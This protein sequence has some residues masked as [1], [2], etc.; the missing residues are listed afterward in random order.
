M[1]SENLI[2]TV[3]RDEVQRLKDEKIVTGGMIPKVDACLDALS[4]N[5]TKTHIV[6]GR[7]PHAVLLE[8]FTKE[9]VG[10]QIVR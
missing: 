3:K 7:V 10:T 6:T 4:S 1:K 5:V 9:G 8:V 2:S